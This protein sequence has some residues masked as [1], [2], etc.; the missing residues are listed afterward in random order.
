ML[1]AEGVYRRPLP[2]SVIES[3]QKIGFIM[4]LALVIMATYNDISRFWISML[5]GV[6]GYFQ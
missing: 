3:F 5:E 2:N 6:V 4:V 1:I